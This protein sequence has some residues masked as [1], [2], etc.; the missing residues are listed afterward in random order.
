MIYLRLKVNLS[1]LLEDGNWSLHPGDMIVLQKIGIRSQEIYEPR[2]SVQY[3]HTCSY[4]LT[5]VEYS[6]YKD[7]GKAFKGDG[8][9]HWVWMPCNSVDTLMAISQG[10]PYYQRGKTQ[11][12]SDLISSGIDLDGVFD[13][14]SV[15]Y[16]RD[17]IIDNVLDGE[18]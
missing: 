16:N 3:I 8:E 7:L 18:R 12:Y 15:Q 1:V 9:K 4:L 11:T 13:D 14:V 5:A 6:T 10:P 2:Q 17:R